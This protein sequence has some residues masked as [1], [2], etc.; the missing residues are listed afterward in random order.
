MYT[1]KYIFIYISRISIKYILIC[2]PASIRQVLKTHKPQTSNLTLW[3][4]LDPLDA[5]AHPSAGAISGRKGEP[6]TTPGTSLRKGMSPFDLINDRFDVDTV[7]SSPFIPYIYM[8]FQCKCTHKM[9]P[10]ATSLIFVFFEY[11]ST[12][13][14][15][16]MPSFSSNMSDCCRDSQSS[17]WF[18]RL[19]GSFGG[20]TV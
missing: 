16:F 14:K 17:P 15:L 8:V 3:Y 12:G 4:C 5:K 10:F 1:Y 18:P 7:G 2:T 6:L 9:Y 20:V 19:R 11:D 13:H